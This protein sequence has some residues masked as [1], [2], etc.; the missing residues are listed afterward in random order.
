MKKS[1]AW[2]TVLLGFAAI[3]NAQTLTVGQTAPE[4]T[5]KD[6]RGNAVKLSD[7]KGK[8]VVLEWTN[9]DCPFVKKHYG[10]KNMQ[11]LQ[12]TYTDRGV[13]WLT[14]CS[15]ADGKQGNYSADEW[16]KRIADE[17]ISS[18]AVL[19]DPD[20][21][22]GHAYGAKNTPHLF[23][24]AADGNLAYQGAI[25]D[26]PSTDADDIKG[27]HNYVSAALDELLA[28]KPVSAPLTK[29]YGCGVKY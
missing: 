7:Y 21:A 12:K 17:G 16:T 23:I 2:M 11:Q 5:G 9:P 1:W 13:V 24:V 3:A 19:L 15:S 14:V 26:K 25:D 20:G 8:L 28:G 27:A 10:S 18:T 4:F 22:I 6:S 29:A